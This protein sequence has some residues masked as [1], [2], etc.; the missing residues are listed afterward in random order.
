L[1]LNHAHNRFSLLR[2]A[3]QKLLLLVRTRHLYARFFHQ[4]AP[5]ENPFARFR[6]VSVSLLLWVEI[7][8]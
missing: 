2:R 7:K 5:L 3:P 1:I 6:V 4:L 8:I